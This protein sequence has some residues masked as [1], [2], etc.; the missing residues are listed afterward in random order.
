MSGPPLGDP[1]RLVVRVYYEDTDFS[2]VVYHA[3]YLRFFERGRTELLRDLGVHQ[4]ALHEGMNG[5][6]PAAFAVRH[7]EVD[8]LSPALMDD[9]L[10]VETSV[11]ALGGASVT[12]RQEIRREGAVL[13]RAVV[14]IALVQAGRARRLPAEL[15]QR[16][17]K[18]SQTPTASDEPG[19]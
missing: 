19:W 14:R 3:N 7:M 12:M 9:A 10:V 1:H 6:A 2:G 15:R 4:S 16:L 13:V 5:D 17:G 8:F 18:R 11:A